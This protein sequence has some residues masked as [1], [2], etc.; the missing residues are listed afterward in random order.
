MI[1][2]IVEREGLGWRSPHARRIPER[3]P[4]KAWVVKKH[5][6]AAVRRLFKS[7][8]TYGVYCYRDIRNVVA[9]YMRFMATRGNGVFQVPEIPTFEMLQKKKFV[10]RLISNYNIWINLPRVRVVRYEDF[11]TDLAAEATAIGEHIG[12]PLPDGEAKRLA[13]K[14][15]IKS[16]Q[17]R[18]KKLRELNNEAA[19]EMHVSTR[20]HPNHIYDGETNWKIDLAPEQIKYIE[21]I[22]GPWLDHKQYRVPA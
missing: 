10:Q 4:R 19:E 6:G 21:S 18:M 20:L 16:Q 17:R 9:S 8:D 1:V 7:P 14:Y 22:A 5:E 3:H 15:S 13:E 2:D 12:L 11:I